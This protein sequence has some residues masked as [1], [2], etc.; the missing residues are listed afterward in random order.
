[1]HVSPVHAGL[2]DLL[3]LAVHVQHRLVDGLLLGRE[4]AV[5]G[6][7]R[8]DVARVALVLRAHVHQQPVA[9]LHQAVV[10]RA[11]VTVVQDAAVA[12]RRADG[13]KRHV[14]AAALEVVRVQEH[15]LDLRLVHLR[16]QRRHVVQVRLR[17]DL[18]HVAVDLDLLR[19]L[20]HTA[21]RDRLEQRHLLD[22][23]LLNAIEVSYVLPLCGRTTGHGVV[24]AVAVLALGH[25]H[26]LR[27]ELLEVGGDVVSVQHL[28]HLVQVLVVAGR[29]DGAH[30]HGEVRGQATRKIGGARLTEE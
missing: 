21:L 29:V 19:G 30:P 10:G 20:D 25:V 28:V 23:V 8:R 27:S 6:A 16:L 4:V 7:H 17:A 1:M 22:G 26:H 9:V 24:A 12:A 3:A 18:A 2:H 13:D 11:R 5:H 14:S 15:G